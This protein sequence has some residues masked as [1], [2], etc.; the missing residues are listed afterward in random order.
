MTQALSTP[1]QARA[2]Q[3]G[4]HIE[5]V[6]VGWMLLE[7]ILSIGAG[8]A[9]HSLLLVA[10]GLDSV[11]ELVSGGILLWRLTVQARGTSLERVEGAER[12]AAWAVALALLGLILY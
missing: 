11:I 5:Q 8:L 1:H 7:A 10:F 2:A 6:T 9:A 12:S 3:A 4:V